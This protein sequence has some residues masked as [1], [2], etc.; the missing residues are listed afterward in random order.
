MCFSLWL[1]KGKT[2]WEKTPVNNNITV[3]GKFLLA[4]EIL[5]KLAH[6]MKINKLNSDLK[7]HR[8]TKAAMNKTHYVRSGER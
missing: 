4:K 5:I 2:K 3:F 1:I 7:Q 6:R 8:I